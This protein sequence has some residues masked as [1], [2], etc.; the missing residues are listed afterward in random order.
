[1]C[2]ECEYKRETRKKF[3]EEK[4]SQ[5][6][7]WL[8]GQE[9]AVSTICS[10]NRVSCKC[11]CKDSRILVCRMAYDSILCE[12]TYSFAWMHANCEQIHCRQRVH[13]LGICDTIK[14]GRLIRMLYLY[15][16]HTPV[17][18]TPHS[19]HISAIHSQK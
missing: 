9:R 14:C 18:R 2:I 5:H 17:Q 15:C 7:V 19:T 4:H 6:V 10:Y 8:S 11:S 3:I 1:M 16:T 12:H 13:Y